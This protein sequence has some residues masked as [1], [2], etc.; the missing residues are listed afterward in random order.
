[1]TL[2]KK[3]ALAKIAGLA[4]NKNGFSYWRASVAP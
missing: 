3:T 2:I 4:H 1:M